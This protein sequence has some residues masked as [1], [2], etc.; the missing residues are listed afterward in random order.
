MAQGKLVL[1]GLWHDIRAGQL[2]HYNA[3]PG[4][5]RLCEGSFKRPY[6]GL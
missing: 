6:Q 5:L 2:H 3:E 1:H 4:H